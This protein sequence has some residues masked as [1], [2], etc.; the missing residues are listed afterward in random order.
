M[1]LFNIK[2]MIVTGV[3]FVFQIEIT[4]LCNLCGR[5]MWTLLLWVISKG[6][7]NVNDIMIHMRDV[8]H[9]NS[10]SMIGGLCIKPHSKSE[11]VSLILSFN[12]IAS[13]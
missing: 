4:F 1:K 7:L 2:S 9:T 11:I 6:L 12:S 13:C 8:H 5:M 10:N 3:I